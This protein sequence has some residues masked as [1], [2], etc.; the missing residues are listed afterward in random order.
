M[1]SPALTHSAPEAFAL[2]AISRELY[3]PAPRP[4]SPLARD[5]FAIMADARP[6]VRP[7]DFF[8]TYGLI[9]CI[10]A[11]GQKLDRKA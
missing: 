1:P 7:S 5:L 4:M 11:I 6:T 2:R 3:A 10:P 8:G 9:A